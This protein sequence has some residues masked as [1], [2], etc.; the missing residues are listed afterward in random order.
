MGISEA[1]VKAADKKMPEGLMHGK[2]GKK[3]HAPSVEGTLSALDKREASW[4]EASKIGTTF[5]LASIQLRRGKTLPQ[6]PTFLC[7]VGLVSI[8]KQASSTFTRPR[9]SLITR[10][11]D[12]E[13]R[14]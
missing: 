12:K 7:D 5:G 1:E 14:P 4:D 8:D 11:L 6:L 2:L 13:L 3:P 9:R 10:N